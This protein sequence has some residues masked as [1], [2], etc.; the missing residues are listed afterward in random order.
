M[1]FSSFEK[2]GLFDR[3]MEPLDNVV[4]VL[5]KTAIETKAS[6]DVCYIFFIHGSF[7]LRRSC[8]RFANG[9]FFLRDGRGDNSHFCEKT[10]EFFKVEFLF[11]PCE[12]VEDILGW[13]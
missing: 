8:N 5:H 2:G 9:S 12:G 1:S 6:E 11:L 7:K 4:E 13:L 3:S 10:N